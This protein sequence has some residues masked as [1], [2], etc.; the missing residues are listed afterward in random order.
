MPDHD[1]DVPFALDPGAFLEVTRMTATDR[2]RRG[3]R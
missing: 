1:I 2:T 3:P